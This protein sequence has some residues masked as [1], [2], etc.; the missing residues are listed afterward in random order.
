MRLD[1]PG[2]LRRF[3]KNALKVTDIRMAFAKGG[4]AVFDYACANQNEST[5]TTDFRLE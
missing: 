1:L 2:N 4:L 5:P 3:D